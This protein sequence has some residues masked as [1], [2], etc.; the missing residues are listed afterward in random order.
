MGPK[1]RTPLLPRA[2]VGTRPRG[3]AP[4]GHAWCPLSGAWVYA[5]AAGSA[6]EQAAARAAAAAAADQRRQQGRRLSADFERRRADDE[7]AAARAAAATAT[8]LPAAAGSGGA[9]AAGSPAVA[10]GGGARGLCK[11]PRCVC[12]RAAA[13]AAARAVVDDPRSFQQQL[14]DVA[15]ADAF[16]AA[17]PPAFAGDG[18]LGAAAR[19]VDRAAAAAIL[20]GLAPRVAEGLTVVVMRKWNDMCAARSDGQAWAGPRFRAGLAAAVL[21]ASD[22]GDA[23]SL[24][25]ADAAYVVVSPK[26]KKGCTGL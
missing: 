15:A 18:G 13:R 14:I 19:A 2:S 22:D 20:A 5:G 21:A 9:S 12:A 11:R 4:A 26:W 3:R 17:A 7:R 8:G 10:G 24:A 6:L 23:A 25:A 1:Q 16:D